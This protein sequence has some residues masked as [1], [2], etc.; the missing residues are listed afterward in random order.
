MFI[1]K[2]IHVYFT[3]FSNMSC[4]CRLSYAFIVSINLSFEF[5]RFFLS[6]FLIFSVSH[7]IF[8]RSWLTVTDAYCMFCVYM[9]IYL[10]M[11]ADRNETTIKRAEWIQF[12]FNRFFFRSFDRRWFCFVY[13]ILNCEW[14]K[15]QNTFKKDND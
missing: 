10:R 14:M 1:V 4:L 12:I 15:W 11:Q 6:C 5:F 8:R 2:L 9:W 7:C 13:K 3:I